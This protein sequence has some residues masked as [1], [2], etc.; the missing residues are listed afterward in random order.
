METHLDHVKQVLTAEQKAARE[1]K[2][3]QLKILSTCTKE[4]D[5]HIEEMLPSMVTM[6]EIFSKINKTEFDLSDEEKYESSATQVRRILLDAF[7]RAKQT[8]SRLKKPAS[9]KKKAG[10]KRAGKNATALNEKAAE[11]KETADNAE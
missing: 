6:A 2:E 7:I 10:P 9:T 5:S 3:A 4:I 8:S 1:T 11:E